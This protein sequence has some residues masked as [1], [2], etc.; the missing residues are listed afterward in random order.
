[1]KDLGIDA[2]TIV[3][4]HWCKL[5]P[6]GKPLADYDT[7]HID[8]DEP[9]EPYFD[10]GNMVTIP[11]LSA[12][13]PDRKKPF[14]VI[15]QRYEEG[16]DLDENESGTEPDIDDD[17]SAEPEDDRTSLGGSETTDVNDSAGIRRGWY[18]RLSAEP[19]KE[20]RDTAALS[21]WHESQ[22]NFHSGSIEDDDTPEDDA[23][24]NGEDDDNPED[25]ADKNGED[26]DQSRGSSGGLRAREASGAVSG[27][28]VLLWK[29][30]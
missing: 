8:D 4:E 12:N 22:L 17:Y 28:T 29:R 15:D 23:D 20:A 2:V 14:E 5:H 21:L 6:I 11:G 19:G 26:Y 16:Q 1:M 25:E 24:E 18:Y 9:V 7:E 10:V 27:S 30:R 3:S 13:N